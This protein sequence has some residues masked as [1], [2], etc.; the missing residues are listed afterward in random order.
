MHD[1]KTYWI[2]LAS[3]HGIGAKTFYQILKNFGSAARFFDAVDKG[4]ELLESVT[5]EL[6]AAAR[7][8]CSSQRI[9]E[10]VCTL[11]QKNIR[12]VTRL[13]DDY[14]EPLARIGW[15]P[16]VLFVRGELPDFSRAVGIVG[17]RRCTRR[18]YEHTRRIASELNMP[19]VSGLARGIDTAAHLGALDAGTPT[20]AVLGCGVDVIYPAE[21]A[22][23]YNNIV[24]SGG[25]VISE[26]PVG[27]EPLA[28]NFPVRNRII[29]GLSR[30][31]LVI[32]SELSGG[33]A[34]TASLAIGSGRD[35]F[36]M[37]GPPYIEGSTL[38][39]ELISNGGIPV[40]TA[41]DIRAY[42]GEVAGETQNTQEEAVA[43]D[44]TQSRILELLKNEDQSAEA[45]AAYTGMGAG[46][47]GI[48][49]TMMELSGLIKRL[50]GGRYGV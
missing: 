20:V 5:A 44:F 11:G 12:A 35:V 17:T 32:E 7:A 49:L 9:T 36:A 2:W 18:A 30:G 47:V 19:V 46:E 13:C 50:P 39:N 3:L 10:L 34:I 21:N 24:S 43:L 22:E 27:A 23:I 25:A 41:D 16:P 48:A 37:P 31:L 40:R 1:E 8:A 6:L 14:P 45:I 38:P 42:Y 29:A 33:T 4:S 15:P 28:A 26:L